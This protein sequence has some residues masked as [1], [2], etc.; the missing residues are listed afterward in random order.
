MAF[1]N[2]YRCIIV[3]DHEID[4]LTTLAFA[5]KYNFLNIVGAFQSAEEALE[6]MDALQPEVLLL[7]IDMG[8]L[9]GLQL[10]RECMEAAACIFITSYPDYA[11][12]SFEVAALDFIVKPIKHDRFA[13]AMV[14]LE[15][16]LELKRKSLLLDHSLDGD[17]VFIKD[18]YEQV[19]IRTHDILYLEALKDYTRIATITRKYTVLQSLG[20][21]LKNVSFNSFVRVHRS[22]AVQKHFIDRITS[23]QVEIGDIKI[24]VGRSFKNELQQLIT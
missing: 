1:S 12:E 15:D 7:D 17:T 22:Y 9:N 11:A 16:Y 19:K 20:N 10:R 8:A 6:Q 5:K 24:P 13:A 4:R 21:F 23:Q 2:T 3:D 18:G 14:R